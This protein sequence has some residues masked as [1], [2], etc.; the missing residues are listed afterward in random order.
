MIPV[1]RERLVLVSPKFMDYGFLPAVILG[2]SMMFS[3]FEIT[4]PS[5]PE[6]VRLM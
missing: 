3:A 1:A 4:V 2:T 6:L 5:M